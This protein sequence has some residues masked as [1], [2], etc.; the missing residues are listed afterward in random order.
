MIRAGLPSPPI[1]MGAAGAAGCVE[2][3]A[4]FAPREFSP[5]EG[6]PL[7]LSSAGSISPFDC[8]LAEQ[9]ASGL[10]RRTA[11]REA[12]LTSGST[13]SA[14]IAGALMTSLLEPDFG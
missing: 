4:K 5:P 7:L 12:F 1:C 10:A 6:A 2:F 13:G 14:D 8:R 9:P 3:A 11:S